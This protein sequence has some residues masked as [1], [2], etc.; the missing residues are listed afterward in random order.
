[1]AERLFQARMSSSN[2]WTA[3]SAGTAAARGWPASLE[4]IQ[5][6]KEK[7]LDLSDHVSQPISRELLQDAQYIFTMTERHKQDI[8]SFDPSVAD[9]IHVVTSFGI[10]KE[11]AGVPDPI[12][13]S[14]D[15]YRHTRDVLESAIA[16]IILYIMDKEQPN[17]AE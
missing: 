14:I 15:V 13:L 7:D 12:G 4:A 16:D 17:K 10:S 8:L 2:G 1:M 3:A 5:A 9:R 6:L 11:N